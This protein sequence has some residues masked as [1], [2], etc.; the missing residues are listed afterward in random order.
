MPTGDPVCFSSRS[1]QHMLLILRMISLFF[2][3]THVYVLYHL[4]VTLLALLFR[5]VYSHP[6]VT[7]C[8]VLVLRSTYEVFMVP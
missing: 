2:L 8:A 1:T 7:A 3:C 6:P 4:Y 5:L